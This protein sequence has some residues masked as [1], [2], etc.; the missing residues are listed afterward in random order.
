VNNFT[1]HYEDLDTLRTQWERS[2][3]FGVL[4]ADLSPEASEGERVVISLALPWAGVEARFTGEVIE[5]KGAYAVTELDPF[6]SEAVQALVDAG[7][8]DAASELGGAEPS[9]G[10]SEAVPSAQFQPERAAVE[11]RAEASA[12]SA[13]ATDSRPPV[14]PVPRSPVS[15][16][17]VPQ[18]E[19]SL[20]QRESLPQPTGDPNDIATIVAAEGP[21]SLSSEALLHAPTQ[22]GNFAKISWREVLLHFYE[23]RATGIL[24]IEGFRENRWCYLLEGRPV[25]FL[26]DRSYNGEFLSDVLIGEGTVSPEVWAE[27]LRARQATGIPAGEYLV[28]TRQLDRSLLNQAL[29]KRAQRITRKLMGMNFGTFR[30]HPYRE[31]VGLFPFESVPVL[32]VV[33]EEQR[34]AVEA[35]PDDV[36][37]GQASPYY[38]LH[39]RLVP[40]RLGLLKEMPFSEEER[41]LVL[42]VLP[43]NWVLGELVSLREMREA[44]LVRFLMVLRELGL[45]EFS[46]DEGGGKERNRAEREVYAELKA[47]DRRHEFAALGTH[48]SSGEEEIR[49]G[50]R[51]LLDRFSEA[52]Y[53]NL[54]DEKIADLIAQLHSLADGAL[55]RI[56]KLADRRR[57]RR[58]LVGADEIR[59]AAEILHGHA[60]TARSESNHSLVRACCQR[61]IDLDPEGREGQDFQSRAR[62]WLSESAVAAAPLPTDSEFN[63]IRQDLARL[64]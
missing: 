22:H 12:K 33:L 24:A 54:V 53:G 40:S 27:A 57:V 35:L 15:Q 13:S 42:E 48:W 39:C 16:A 52:H 61:V 17:A 34:S 41:R 18:A 60:A 55:Q 8:S 47:V 9:P 20:E 4:V 49:S 59:L 25:H 51:A 2:L 5:A 37:L 10:L 50:H 3:Q 30:F 26:A 29:S 11:P 1:S 43:A 6:S 45:V 56:E 38:A 36:L 46:R 63:V 44:T 58:S 31:L 21:G 14:K 62:K 19:P 23:Q 32:Q 64:N 28:A 7:L